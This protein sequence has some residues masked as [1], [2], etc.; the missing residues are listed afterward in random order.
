MTYVGTK[1][2]E[3]KLYNSNDDLLDTLS[4]SIEG[5]NTA[6]NVPTIYE[7]D[8]S[9]W[10][11]PSSISV[12]QGI[13]LIYRVELSDDNNDP[14]ELLRNI[15][16][17]GTSQTTTD[18]NVP[19]EG[20]VYIGQ[21]PDSDGSTNLFEVRMNTLNRQRGPPYTF[22]DKAGETGETSL[23]GTS[24]ETDIYVQ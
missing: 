22:G 6:P 16:S 21:D 14:L 7:W 2:L 19:N 11:E 17:W 3:A 12:F 13:P 9:A 20:D 15:S 4:D 23:P 24:A 18:Y 10:T 8:G 5:L 1:T